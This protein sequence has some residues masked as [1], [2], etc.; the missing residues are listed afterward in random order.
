MLGVALGVSITVALDLSIQ[1]SREA[2]RVSSET[3]GGRATHAVLGG[4]GGIPDDLP[5]LLTTAGG[6]RAVAPVVEGYAR[7]PAIPDRTLRVLGV[8]PLAEAP[9]RPFLGG[10]PGSEGGLDGSRLLVESGA[11]LLSTQTAR[12]LGVGVGDP[13]PLIAGPSPHTLRVL[14]ILEPEDAWS[15]QGLLDL[16]VV[17][18]AEAQVLF[19]RPGTLD[20][21]DLLLDRSD[22]DRAL[23]AIEAHLPPGTRIEPA[24]TRTRSMQE[25]LAA[26]DLN[27]TALSLLGLVF[28]AFLIYNTMTF[29]I[30]QRRELFGTLRA[31]G[32][33]RGE[34][35]KGTLAEAA[36]L[37]VVGST[38]GV[39]LGVV[40]GR[41]LV[42]L[43]TRTINDLYLVVSVDALALPPEV[44][45]RGGLL[46]VVVTLLASLPPA[47]EA[48][49]ASLTDALRRSTVESSARRLVPLAAV[50]G[51]WLAVVGIALMVATERSI[52]AA[53]GG[54][55]GILLGLA[56]LVPLATVGIAGILRPLLARFTGVIGAMAVRGVVTSLSR[57]APAMA[58]LVVAVSVTVGLGAM[59]ESFRGSVVRW[60]D[61]TLQADLYVSPPSTVSARLGGEL[62]PLVLEVARAHPGVEGVSTYRAIEFESAYGWTRLVALDLHARGRDA[63]DLMGGAGDGETD[64]FVGGEGALVSEPFAFRHGLAAGDTLR[65]PSDAGVLEL[66]ILAIFRDYGSELGTI[67]IPRSRWDSEWTDRGVS[68]L[69]VFLAPGADPARVAVELREAAPSGFPLVVRDQGALRARSLEVFDRTFEV[70]RVLRLLAFLVAFIAVLSALMALQLERSREFG[71]LR[72]GG[73]TTRQG[74]GLV[75]AQTAVMGGVAGVLSLPVGAALA[76]MMVHVVNRRSFGWTIELAIPPSLPLQ[77]LLLGLLGALLAGVYPSWRL[78]RTPPSEAL[79]E[80]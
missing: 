78:A 1:S 23:A 79:R 64:R 62:P 68:S 21:I 9:F 37:G 52:L 42:R 32:V 55:F 24:G 19:G 12:A 14:G 53:F 56:L 16:L 18:I 58:A 27:L 20:R 11:A 54:V 28:G 63:L 43:I 15:R 77:A 67:M 40:L 31:L 74:W 72:A 39:L 5:A 36:L 25:M 57:T 61:V 59:I 73:M 10:T 48:A 30:V 34:I 8:D 49:R 35:L 6:L 17:D 13:L 7:H 2:F 71:V 60:L 26:F 4:P 45:L 70:T 46:G 75:T 29:S 47:R 22:E 65:L 76:W 66:P 3:V 50:G 44:L 38:L 33:T 80:R 51:T 69:G 41:G